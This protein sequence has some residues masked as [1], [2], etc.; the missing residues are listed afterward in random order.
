M[1]RGDPAGAGASSV[2]VPAVAAVGAGLLI[3]MQSR[4]NGA[5]AVQL[6]TG[7]QAAVLSFGSGFV[8][9]CILA[10]TVRSVRRGIGA[11]RPAVRRG[12]LKPW[13]LLGG[14]I[15][16]FFVA[17]QSAAVPVVGVAVF[18]V[19]VV[20][21]QSASSIL[22]DRAGLGPAGVQA[23]TA[24]RVTSAALA[25]VAVGVAV[26]GRFGTAGFS[27]LPVVVAAVAGIGIA[28]QQAINGRVGAAAG[29]PLSATWLN[30]G[31][32]TAGLV[33]ALG[34]SAGFLGGTVSALPTDPEDLWLFLGGL[35]GIGFIAVAAWAVRP[36][37][38]LLFALLSIGGQ[39][40]GAL[41][42]D[43][44]VPTTAGGASWRL[45]AGVALAG[46]AIAVAVLPRVAHR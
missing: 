15:G 35:L 6:G 17:V 28:V 12:D 1:R 20:A 4:V 44:L 27:I 16:G 41:L 34:L 45:A 3:A 13:Q 23:V 25:V 2:A 14:L 33:T 37:G 18:T 30:F 43:V 24:R 21:G 9:L 32:G 31:L 10:L 8:I 40:A 7:L 5:L 42:L 38:V 11:L 36:L 26:S 22:V 46:V 19:A 29:N 39:L